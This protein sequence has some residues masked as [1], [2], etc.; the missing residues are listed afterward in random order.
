[1]EGNLAHLMAVRMIGEGRSWSPSSACHMAKVE[2]S[3]TTKK[4][5]VGVSGKLIIKTSPRSHLFELAQRTPIQASFY[6]HLSPHSIDLFRIDLIP[7]VY[8]LGSRVQ[9]HAIGHH[10]LIQIIYPTIS[11][12]AVEILI[13]GQLGQVRRN[14]RRCH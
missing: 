6:R 5:N 13:S 1:M 2:N 12:P 7:S 14:S 11:H 8:R 4:P 3:L 9:I 10:R